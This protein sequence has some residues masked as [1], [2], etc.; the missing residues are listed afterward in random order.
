[1]NGPRAGDV[2]QQ[3]GEDGAVAGA[4]NQ[5]HGRQDP[6]IPTGTVPPWVFFSYFNSIELVCIEIE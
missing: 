4:D 3:E 2:H 5:Q 6:Y 1:M